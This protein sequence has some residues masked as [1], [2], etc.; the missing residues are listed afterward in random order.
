MLDELRERLNKKIANCSE[1]DREK[2][3]LIE[4]I[5]LMDKWYN[6]L[7]ADDVISILIDLEYTKEEAK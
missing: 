2:Y 4:I 5:M 6:E 3:Y 1:E 7:D